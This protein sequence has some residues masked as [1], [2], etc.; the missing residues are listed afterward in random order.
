M[1]GGSIVIV[2]HSEENFDTSEM[3]MLAAV[4]GRRGKVETEHV[5]WATQG[6]LGGFAHPVIDDAE[7]LYPVDN[8]AVLAAFDVRPGGRCG[9][10]TS[11]RFRRARR[12]SPTASSTSEP[13][14]GS[15]TSLSRRADGVEVLDEDWLGSADRRPEIDRR[16]AGRFQR[17]RLH[18][19]D[20]RALRDRPKGT[21]DGAAVSRAASNAA[22]AAAPPAWRPGHRRACSC[23]R[24]T[25]RSRRAQAQKFQAR[26]VRRQR[27]AAGRGQ[28]GDA[29]RSRA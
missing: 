4:D 23:S 17:P 1:V 5:K 25:S 10:R 7:R 19:V 20:G 27:Q 6:F 11:A 29:G 9:T 16:L 8:G 15:S 12:C 3:G 26:A 18:R 28:S 22:P 2:T 13:R 14:T 21:P 24:R